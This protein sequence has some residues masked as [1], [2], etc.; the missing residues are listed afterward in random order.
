[1]AL[2]KHWINFV[3]TL[4]VSNKNKYYIHFIRS[5]PI[6]WIPDAIEKTPDVNSRN[7]KRNQFMIYDNL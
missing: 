3:L 4:Q 5:V 1:M 6:S 2:L 7:V